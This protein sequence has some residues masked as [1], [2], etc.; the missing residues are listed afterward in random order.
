MYVRTYVRNIR[1]STRGKTDRYNQT[2]IYYNNRKEKVV[3]VL[4]QILTVEVSGLSER[5]ITLFRVIDRWI[6]TRKDSIN[7][8]REF[9][10]DYAGSFVRSFVRVGEK[11]PKCPFVKVRMHEAFRVTV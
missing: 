4:T 7:E 8:T 2:A 11:L 3:K 10:I 1:A 9:N 5:N 6:D